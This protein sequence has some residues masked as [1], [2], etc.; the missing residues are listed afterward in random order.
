MNPGVPIVVMTQEITFDF[1]SS[2]DSYTKHVSLAYNLGYGEAMGV[3]HDKDGVFDFEAGFRITSSMDRRG[4]TVTFTIE[5][6][7]TAEKQL[8]FASHITSQQLADS[9]NHVVQTGSNL[10]DVLPPTAGSITI[11]D[12]HVKKGT[13]DTND[14]STPGSDDDSDDRPSK[15]KFVKLCLSFIAAIVAAVGLGYGGFVLI[16]RRR[17]GN[18]NNDSE[19]VE[20]PSFNSQADVPALQFNPE[21]GNHEHVPIGTLELEMDD[22]PVDEEDDH[23][24]FAEA[25]LQIASKEAEDA[26][27]CDEEKA[28]LILDSN[29]PRM[30]P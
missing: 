5:G 26:T 19:S 10:Y 21:S 17:Q 3:I 28:S 14:D 13:P 15:M 22:T 12:A 18:G 2:S 7:A 8:E 1:I 16:K 4:S 27:P 20:M 30:S 25:S 29:T 23:V 24:S 9:I 6:P 11:S